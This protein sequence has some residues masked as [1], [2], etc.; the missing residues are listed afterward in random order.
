M[1]TAAPQVRTEHLQRLALLQ[2]SRE[3]PQQVA[4]AEGLIKAIF[5]NLATGLC[6]DMYN[7]KYSL[8][9]MHT[10]LDTAERDYNKVIYGLVKQDLRNARAV[11]EYCRSTKEQLSKIPK[12][13][14][15]TAEMISTVL[16]ACQIMRTI[17]WDAA[18]LPYMYQQP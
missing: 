16:D 8:E 5:A 12:G 15:F 9:S 7:P 17:G 1:S 3:F 13:H 18:T 2:N 10:R 11:V 14:P 4:E 6:A